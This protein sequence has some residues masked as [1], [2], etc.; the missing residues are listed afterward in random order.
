VQLTATIDATYAQMPF[1]A[2]SQVLTGPMSPK[3]AGVQLDW[4]YPSEL[5][6][7][8]VATE[9]LV[10]GAGF[11]TSTG[12]E[13]RSELLLTA[14]EDPGAPTDPQ[15][16]AKGELVVQPT[17]NEQLLLVVFPTMDPRVRS[18]LLA[19]PKRSDPA[20]IEV[21]WH[22]R[23]NC[24]TFSDGAWTGSAPI[25]GSLRSF[26][27]Q[28]ELTVDSGDISFEIV[29]AGGQVV[30][31]EA[32]LNAA[33]SG[34]IAE[35]PIVGTLRGQGPVSGSANDVTITWTSALVSLSVDGLPSTE[36]PVTDGVGRFTP[37]G[38]DCTTVTGDLLAFARESALSG[39]VDATIT[40]PFTAR[41]S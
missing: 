24:G 36:L 8:V 23:D 17:T 13:G 33:V 38:G 18:A 22:Q 12:R 11:T 14:V 39:G 28:A 32:R 35:T 6:G 31:G 16:T 2:V 15:H 9:D 4:L 40:A 25:T 37:T 41:R 10:A 27:G 26:D 1:D 21:S 5:L 19:M 30:G 7:H 20:V 29:V 3:P 34:T